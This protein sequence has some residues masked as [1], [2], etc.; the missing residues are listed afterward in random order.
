MVGVSP[1]EREENEE[2]QMA[3]KHDTVPML[4]ERSVL[5]AALLRP[6]QLMLFDL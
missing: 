5:R 6:K 1:A 4:P 2:K 3:K